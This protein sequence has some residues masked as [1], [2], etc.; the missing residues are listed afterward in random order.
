MRLVIFEAVEVLVALAAGL[1]LVGFVLLHA[2]GA[3]VGLEGVRVDDGEG[4]VGVGVEGLR[5]VAVLCVLVS[6]TEVLD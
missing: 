5:V 2:L 4:A 3:R 1:A 6:A